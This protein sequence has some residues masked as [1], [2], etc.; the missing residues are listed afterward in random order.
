MPALLQA[1]A[2]SGVARS[3]PL[4]TRVPTVRTEIA[5]FKALRNATVNRR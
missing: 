1:L 4:P 3:L 2:A 5:E